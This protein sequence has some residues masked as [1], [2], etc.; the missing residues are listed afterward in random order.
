MA[1]ACGVTVEN[2][3]RQVGISSRTAY[4]RLTDPSF[5]QRLE[6][7]RGDM[8]SR[9]AGTLTAAAS[10]AVRTLLELLKNPT[11]ASVR[12]GAARAVL[13]IGMKVREMADLEEG[14]AAL[15][16]LSAAQQDRD[17]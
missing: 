3:A 14:L 6:T 16:Q 4:R 13:E 12:L 10:E 7:L 11:S 5:R 1:L 9:T 2:A 17:R 8:V 15:E